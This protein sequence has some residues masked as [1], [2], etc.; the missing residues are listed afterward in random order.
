MAFDPDAFLAD[1]GKKQGFDPDAFL[2]SYAAP[3]ES[4]QTT[5]AQ[6][7]QRK[8]SLGEKIRGVAYPV[9]EAVGAGLGGLVGTGVGPAG[10]VAGASLGY[11]G[12]KGVENIL[13]QYTNAAQPETLAQAAARTAKDVATGAMYEMGG[14]ILGKGI[15]AGA[16]L[17]KK[18]TAPTVQQVKA[19]ANKAYESAK[20][21]GATFDVSAPASNVLTKIENE[22]YDPVQ[23]PKLASAVA[24][25]EELQAKSAAGKPAEVKD[26]IILN[27]RFNRSIRGTPDERRIAGIA[28]DEFTNALAQINPKVMS[29]IEQGNALW[30]Q[31][32]KSQRIANIVKEAEESSAPTSE[33]IKKKFANLLKNPSGFTKEE[34]ATI[35]DI[36][37]GNITTNALSFLGNLAPGKNVA[38]VLKLLGY[39]EAFKVSPALSLSLA[40]AGT[41]ARGAANILAKNRANQ[42]AEQILGGRMTSPNALVAPGISQRITPAGLVLGGGLANQLQ[43]QQ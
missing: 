3:T 41:A 16:E 32:A 36:S 25:L 27:R 24:K 17:F 28:S 22:I 35:R 34:Q 39:E 13:D 42:L 14:Q 26:I 31:A 19:E 5:Q 29:D 1:K 20:Q 18:S 33:A 6:D 21:S 30:S 43:G 38:G 40:G 37:E 15:A 11:A 8:P 12:V 9:A 2:S 4:Q 10:T 23:H 7:Y